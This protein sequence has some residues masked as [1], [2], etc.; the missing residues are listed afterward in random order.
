MC[1]DVIMNRQRKSND[2][3]EKCRSE[4]NRLYVK[5]DFFDALIKYN[6]SLCCAEMKSENVGLAYA[7][8]SAVYFEMNLFDKCLE[9]IQLARNNFYPSSKL[10]ILAKR[11]EKS[12]TKMKSSNVKS[13][14]HSLETFFKLSYE[15]HAK[16]PCLAKCL[17]LR[18][19]KK[20]GRH[21]ITTRHLNVGDVIATDIAQFKVIKADSRYDT[22]FDT[23]IFQRCSNCLSDNLLSL[24]PCS[25]CC[26]TMYCSAKCMKS[27]YQRYHRFECEIIDE[28][29]KL[30]IEHASLRILF[31]GLSL[32]EDDIYE[33][34]NYLNK[35]KTLT[36][37]DCKKSFSKLNNKKSHDED[38]DDYDD[39]DEKKKIFSTTISLASSDFE[40]PFQPLSS[41]YDYE[42]IF[43]IF[44]CSPKLKS[45][46]SAM[47]ESN[48]IFLR[49]L[50][51]VLNRIGLNYMHGVGKFQL[52]L[53]NFFLDNFCM[54]FD[55]SF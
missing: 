42:K 32:F 55:I 19:N 40:L 50:L 45:L 30:G 5:K 36:I 25:L 22:C 18:N 7:N 21:I 12:K 35:E 11:E 16:L 54:H 23:N 3:S 37:F 1:C 51:S 39:N 9:N 8:R 2:Y 6:E 27:A 14:D 10:E 31:E 29:L 17:E 49:N 15:S 4:A 38:D 28:L 48:K 43:K 33:M 44:Q 13:N 53:L 26:K 24:I 52:N 47:N 41:N 34:E 20:Y 46:C